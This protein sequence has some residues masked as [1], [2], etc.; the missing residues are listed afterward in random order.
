M[1]TW[2]QHRW[3]TNKRRNVAELITFC[4]CRYSCVVSA[5]HFFIEIIQESTGEAYDKVPS[6][7]WRE[8][9]KSGNKSD[10]FIKTARFRSLLLEQLENLIKQ[11]RSLA[12]WKLYGLFV[13]WNYFVCRKKWLFARENE[14]F[15]G[16]LG[17]GQIRNSRLKRFV[18]YVI[19]FVSRN[20]IISW[21]LSYAIY[22][23]GCQ[24][25]K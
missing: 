24:L 2:M 9:I 22:R 19:E 1:K 4:I 14:L 7:N 23:F 5:R 3:E 12:R 18:T 10:N 17:V 6:C 16:T 21:Q 25:S 20:L 8:I 15:K 13:S 11:V